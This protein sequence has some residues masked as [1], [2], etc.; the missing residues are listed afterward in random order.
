MEVLE[1]KWLS[2][3]LHINTAPRTQQA[4]SVASIL[5]WLMGLLGVKCVLAEE[6]SAVVGQLT[7]VSVTVEDFMFISFGG[8]PIVT[9]VTVV[10]GFHLHQVGK[11]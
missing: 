10:M 5:Q 3:V 9:S 2:L 11:V 4:G 7:S 1:I 8:H 6:Q